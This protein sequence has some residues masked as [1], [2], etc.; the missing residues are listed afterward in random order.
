L[1]R[2]NLITTNTYTYALAARNDWVSNTFDNSIAYPSASMSFIP[3]KAFSDITSKEW[4]KFPE[5]K[6]RLGT[7]AGF[8]SWLSG[9]KYH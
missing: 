2:L 9:C 1:D 8:A 5:V 4:Y 3:S 6:S 7:S